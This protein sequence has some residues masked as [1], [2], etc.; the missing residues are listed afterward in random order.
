MQECC[1]SLITFPRPLEILDAFLA[2]RALIHLN[3]EKT[4]VRYGRVQESCHCRNRNLLTSLCARS[5]IADILH[6]CN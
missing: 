4:C 5:S 2:M 3:E 6:Y 1:T